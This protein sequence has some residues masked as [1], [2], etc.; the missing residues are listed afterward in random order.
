MVGNIPIAL[1]QHFRP[2]T[3]FE[4]RTGC[5]GD[6][7][8]QGRL[9]SEWDMERQHQLFATDFSGATGGSNKFSINTAA[10]T[11]SDKLPDWWEAQ[12]SLGNGATGDNGPDGDPDKDGQSN[13]LE[14]ALNSNPMANSTN[15]LPKGFVQ[16]NPG[17]GQSYLTFNYRRRIGINSLNYEIQ[18]S[19]DCISW[20][21]DG[22]TYQQLGAMPLGDGSTEEVSVRVLPAISPGNAGRFVRLRVTAQ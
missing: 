3:H 22:A 16:Q 7:E 19:S 14:Y 8:S 10:D 5:I 17:D 9:H 2:A 18:T 21:P 1:D 13:L 20:T 12:N 11:D 15:Q 6:A 4:P